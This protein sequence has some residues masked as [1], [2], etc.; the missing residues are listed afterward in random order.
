MIQSFLAEEVKKLKLSVDEQIKTTE[1]TL[2]KKIE[3]AEGGSPRK[4]SAKSRRK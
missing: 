3:T 1:D 4:G 2:N